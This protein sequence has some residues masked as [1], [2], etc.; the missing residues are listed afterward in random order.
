MSVLFVLT[1]D[2]SDPERFA[3][4]NPGS[5]PAIGATIAKHGGDLVFGAAPET[6]KGEASHSAVGIQFPDADAAKAWLDEPD[7]AE[8][9]AIRLESTT[10]ITSYIVETRS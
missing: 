6:L 10:N 5:L 1:Y 7:Y 3:D 4:Y 9:K 8:A 2:V